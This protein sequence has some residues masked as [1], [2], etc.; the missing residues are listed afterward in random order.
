MKR[1]GA[2]FSGMTFGVRFNI[3][4]LTPVWTG[5]QGDTVLRLKGGVSLDPTPVVPKPYCTVLYQQR[6]HGRVETLQ[7][8]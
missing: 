6:R 8:T 5:P 4:D 3:D 1:F 2:S 7:Q